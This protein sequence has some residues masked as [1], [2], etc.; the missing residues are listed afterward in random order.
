MD[1]TARRT[2]ARRVKWVLVAMPVLAVATC[3]VSW[4]K[5]G[6][7][8]NHGN[9]EVAMREHQ[10]AWKK[11]VIGDEISR[12][13][14]YIIARSHG[15][16]C[17]TDEAE[18]ANVSMDELIDQRIL[19]KGTRVACVFTLRSKWPRGL[20]Q[21]HLWVTELLP[22]SENRLRIVRTTHETRGIDM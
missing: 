10:E 18:W 21:H 11:T 20:I 17:R 15:G 8:N 22:L 13:H 14:M 12:T 3:A 19:S 7:Y 16:H 5:S 1:E 4:N 2:R 9:P 6:L